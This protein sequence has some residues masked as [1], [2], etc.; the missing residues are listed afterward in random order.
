M[1]SDIDFTVLEKHY[2][3]HPQKKLLNHMIPQTKKQYST[4]YS[5][6]KDISKII[7]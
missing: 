3:E 4:C 1:W 5:K 2:W 7:F 6:F